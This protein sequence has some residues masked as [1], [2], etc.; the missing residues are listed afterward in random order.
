MLTR[1]ISLSAHGAARRRA[2]RPGRSATARRATPSI[3]SCCAPRLPG[4]G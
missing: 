2:C 1:D 4:R 3:P